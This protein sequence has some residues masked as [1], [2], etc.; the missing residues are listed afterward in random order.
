M[1]RKKSKGP[2][3]NKILKQKIIEKTLVLPRNSEIT[4]SITNN[5]YNVHN[6][7]TYVKVL[8]NDDMIGHKLGE[9]VPTRAVFS[10]KSKK[11]KKK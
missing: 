8:I 9:F 11:Q 2:F 4:S 7:R 10:F 5:Y 1:S 3:I 6:G